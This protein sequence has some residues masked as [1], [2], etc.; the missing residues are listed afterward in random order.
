MK[1]VDKMHRFDLKGR[2]LVVK[3][4]FDVERDKTGRIVK[5][6]G[7]GG[8]GKI[9]LYFWVKFDKKKSLKGTR[10]IK[11]LANHFKSIKV[12][13]VTFDKFTFLSF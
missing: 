13:Y 4:D 7:M 5:G 2:K 8:G 3:E 12:V 11:E 9:N 10:F 1:A 6:S